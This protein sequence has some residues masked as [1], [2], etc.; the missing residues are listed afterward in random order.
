MSTRLCN[1]VF[2][3]TLLVIDLL[4]NITQNLFSPFRANS[5]HIRDIDS[6]AFAIVVIQIIAILCVIIDLILYLYHAADKL[7]QYY[8][9][10][11]QKA[12]SVSA[13]SCFLPQRMALKLVL[14]K[15]WWSLLVGAIYLVLTIILQIIRLNPE[16][17]YSVTSNDFNSSLPPVDKENGSELL[18]ALEELKNRS[19]PDY[20]IFK[21]NLIPVAVLLAHKLTSTCYYVSF[22]VVYKTSP[23]QVMYKNSK[24]ATNAAG[25]GES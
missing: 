19:S 17:Q 5:F 1:I 12:T 9:A 20:D 4:I 16:W 3:Y 6:F 2:V 10:Q 23:D 14:D 25:K 24:K 22:F 15:Y 21:Q 18:S 8:W 7:C 11:L 13:M